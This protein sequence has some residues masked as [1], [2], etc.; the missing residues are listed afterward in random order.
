MLVLVVVSVVV[1]VVVSLVVLPKFTFVANTPVGI[2]VWT[3]E[4]SMK[5]TA[6]SD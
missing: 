4:P 2:V 3:L 6:A 1:L 5:V